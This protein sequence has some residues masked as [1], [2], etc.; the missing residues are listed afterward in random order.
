MTDEPLGRARA[1]MVAEQIEARGIADPA[2]LEAMRTVPRER[3]VPREMRGYAFRD[4]PLPIEAGQT[5]SQPSIVA[6]M[7]A[8]AGIESG[9]RVLEVGAGSG[10]AA[11]VMGQLAAEVYGIERHEILADLAAQRMRDLDYDNVTIRHGD[12]TKG[13]AEKAPFDAILVAAQGAAVPE[14]LS[15]QLA[16]GGRIVIP[17]GGRSMQALKKYTKRSDGSLA[18]E[19][20]GHVRFVPLVEGD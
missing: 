17:I 10:Y 11:A 16:Q 20:L 14:A 15:E 19:D 7:I 1:R 3:F 6:E 9:D 13:W 12:G 18:E 8:A 4:G 5:I 2:L